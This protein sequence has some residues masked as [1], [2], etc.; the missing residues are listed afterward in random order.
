[1]ALTAKPISTISYNSEAHLKRVLDQYF[2]SGRI[3][4][5]RYICHEG[6]DGD[7]D[8]IHLYVVPNRRIDTVQFREEFKEVVPFDDKPLG[9]MPFRKS[10]NEHW[11]M[12]AIH[13]PDYLKAHKSDNDGD[14]KKL[15][16]VEQIVT[17]FPDQLMRDYK[18][19]LS[20]RNTN[21]Q[22]IINRVRKGDKLVDIAYE[23]DIKPNEIVAMMNLYRMQDAID[24]VNRINQIKHQEAEQI[25]KAI[26]VFGKVKTEEELGGTKQEKRLGL[27]KVL[28]KEYTLDMITGE[29]V[30]TDNKVVTKGEEDDER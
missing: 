5:Y 13:D 24:E 19:A 9:C 29:Y 15:Y 11:L 16:T 30:E 26:D 3:E 6:E 12:Y 17:P 23:E 4:D 22:K 8:H 21:N 7:K 10:S 1:M 27:R 28:E 14:G 18:K 20:L 2:D 25:S